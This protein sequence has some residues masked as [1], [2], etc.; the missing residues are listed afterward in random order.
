MTVQW[1]GV[2]L[3]ATRGQAVGVC[4]VRGHQH[5]DLIH[6]GSITSYVVG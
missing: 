2:C 6:G 5:K 4:G 1:E 3:C